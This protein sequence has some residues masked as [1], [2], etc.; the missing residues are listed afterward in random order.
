MLLNIPID[1]IPLYTGFFSFIEKIILGKILKIINIIN[2]K[3]IIYSMAHLNINAIIYNI[4]ANRR[5]L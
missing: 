1:K 3:K 5:I 4:K 2:S